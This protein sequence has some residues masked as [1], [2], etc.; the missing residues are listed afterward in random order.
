M[1]EATAWKKKKEGGGVT[2]FLRVFL[3]LDQKRVVEIVTQAEAKAN[4]VGPHLDI[5]NVGSEKT[6]L[7]QSK[8]LIAASIRRGHCP[9]ITAA[10][11][12]PFC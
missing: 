7:A 3:H 9:R 11:S 5:P 10:W 2:T 6:P 4:A 1:L 12:S 8:Q